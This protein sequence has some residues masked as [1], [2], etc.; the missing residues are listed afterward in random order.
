MK[1]KYTTVKIVGDD[2]FFEDKKIQKE[3]EKIKKLISKN[4]GTKFEK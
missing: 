2:K 3:M 1:S 4:K